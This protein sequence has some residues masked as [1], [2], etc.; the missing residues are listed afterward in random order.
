MLSTACRRC[1]KPEGSF[2]VELCFCA[3][4][5][6]PCRNRNASSTPAIIYKHFCLCCLQLQVWFGSDLTTNV[7]R[8]LTSGKYQEWR[9]V[10]HTNVLVTQNVDQAK[11]TAQ[12]QTR[13]DDYKHSNG[14]LH[15]DIQN[16]WDNFRQLNDIII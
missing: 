8:R 1:D 9:N 5:T 16:N 11:T 7:H 12:C 4:C 15:H 14:Y 13:T 3:S 6:Q 10:E 2:G